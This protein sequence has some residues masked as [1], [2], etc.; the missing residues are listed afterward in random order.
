M[1]TDPRIFDCDD[2]NPAL[3][4]F[5]WDKDVPKRIET[6][7]MTRLCK[8]FMSALHR[9]RAEKPGPKRVSVLNKRLA[10]RDRPLTPEVIDQLVMARQ[11]MIRANGMIDIPPS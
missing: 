4:Q 2:V 6:Q 3:V 10:L 5:E 11:I 1:E 7:Q 9:E 8:N